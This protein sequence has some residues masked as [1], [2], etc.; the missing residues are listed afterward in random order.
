M[1]QNRLPVP[2]SSD[3]QGFACG[4]C[5]R[6]LDGNTCRHHPGTELLDLSLEGD[7]EDAFALR[8]IRRDRRKRG[9]LLL[10]MVLCL[11]VPQGVMYD[12]HSIE[13]SV[14]FDGGPPWWALAVG[15][16]CVASLGM[17]AND[18]FSLFDDGREAWTLK[19]TVN[20]KA[21]RETVEPQEVS[22]SRAAPAS[23][24]DTESP[25]AERDLQRRLAQQRRGRES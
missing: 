19:R 13:P 15:L 14:L 2:S 8:S 1:A 11:L 16:G 24:P 7:A 12:G 10:G 6:V 9:V 3:P 5:G 22:P 18:F 25:V 21:A 4:S 17:L 23:S 20:P